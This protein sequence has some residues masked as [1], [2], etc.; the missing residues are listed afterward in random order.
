MEQCHLHINIVEYRYYLPQDSP[1]YSDN[2]FKEIV[3]YH[4]FEFIVLPKNHTQNK[5]WSIIL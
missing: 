5:Y 1:D 4:C 3:L 2:F